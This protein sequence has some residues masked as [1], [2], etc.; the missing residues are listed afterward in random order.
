MSHLFLTSYT[1]AKLWRLFANVAGIKIEG[2][3]LS[4]VV[5]KWWTQDCCS[6]LKPIMKAVPTIIIWNLWKRR[7]NLKHGKTASFSSL[8]F[9]V[10][11]DLWK[12][13]R[14]V[15]PKLQDLPT[16]WSNI[17]AYL[18][19]Y[20]PELYYLPVYWKPQEGCL[21]CNTDGASRGNPGRS[22]YGFVLRNST[23]ELIYAQGEEIEEGSNLQ[24]EA[25]AIREALA[26]CA[27]EG[28]T[29]VCLQTDSLVLL[30]ILTKVWE[31]PWNI[32]VIVDDIRGLS[33][34][35]Q[36]H[37]QHVYREGNSL[38]DCI[39]NLAF[40]NPGRQIY[41]SFSE[42]PSQAKRILNLDKNQYPSLRIK[43]KQ[44]R[45]RGNGEGGTTLTITP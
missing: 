24:A 27:T 12:L 31:V 23:G 14:I 3:Q 34:E 20:K 29:K 1:A 5:I 43:T 44:I 8:V 41:N 15:H 10:N 42:L 25:I 26:H 16:N 4:Q 37:I 2:L 9:K 21:K 11:S 13:G 28:V 39:A 17:I 30:K 18:E 7:N 6:T 32:A 33:Q 36:V 19:K 22:T 45:R 35:V 38:A 40:D